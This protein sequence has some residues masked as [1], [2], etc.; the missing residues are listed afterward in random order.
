LAAFRKSVR[1]SRLSA[2]SF[3]NVNTGEIAKS[4]HGNTKMANRMESAAL[5][6]ATKVCP[7]KTAP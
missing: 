2:A 7:L 3:G 5:R 1:Y 4:A 6:P